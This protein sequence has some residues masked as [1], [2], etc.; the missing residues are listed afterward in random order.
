[1]ILYQVSKVAPGR[2]QVVAFAD[3]PGWL[4]PPVMVHR[5]LKGRK[6]AEK[7]ARDLAGPSGRVSTLLTQ[8]G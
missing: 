5:D 7:L 3:T 4:G 1:M 8:K 2:W 6:A